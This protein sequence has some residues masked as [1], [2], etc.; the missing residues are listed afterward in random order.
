[1]SD[2][3]LELSKEF[4]DEDP[5]P[6]APATDDKNKSDTGSNVLEFIHDG[7]EDEDGFVADKSGGDFFG[8][9]FLPDNGVIFIDLYFICFD[10]IS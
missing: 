6:V 2:D 3:E 4:D 8:T 1:L 10:F 7:S 9:G 5:Q